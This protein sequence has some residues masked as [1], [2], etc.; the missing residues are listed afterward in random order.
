MNHI[1]LLDDVGLAFKTPLA[2]IFRARL[3]ST[4]NVIIETDDLGID[5]TQRR[6]RFA[7]GIDAAN[8]ES[9]LALD[10]RDQDAFD[11]GVGAGA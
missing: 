4:G 7:V 11:R 3:A 9:T 10:L 8:F 5:R 2:C 6:Y 1:A